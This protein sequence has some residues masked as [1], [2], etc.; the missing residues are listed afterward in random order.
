[1]SR[2]LNLDISVNSVCPHDGVQ[3]KAGELV[4]SED[5]NI[6][7]CGEEGKVVCTEYPCKGKLLQSSPRDNDI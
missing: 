5:C 6:C 4:P 7:V 3:Y 2:C 1:M